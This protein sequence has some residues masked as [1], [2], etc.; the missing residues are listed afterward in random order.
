MDRLRSLYD[1]ANKECAN[2]NC[3]FDY[4]YEMYIET[5]E[6]LTQYQ[7]C[8]EWEEQ[9]ASGFQYKVVATAYLWIRPYANQPIA[10]NDIIG[11]LCFSSVEYNRQIKI[12]V[13]L[14]INMP[15][16]KAILRKTPRKVP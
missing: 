1:A 10:D 4:H 2:D 14:K 13:R 15:L 7:Y 11:E 12:P 16:G 6:K 3:Q 9:K 5:L 8:E